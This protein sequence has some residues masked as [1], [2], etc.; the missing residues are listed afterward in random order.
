M[1]RFFLL[2]IISI[3]SSALFS[4]GVDWNRVIPPAE[5]VELTFEDRLVQLAWMNYSENRIFENEAD[6]T[7]QSIRLARWGWLDD[8][9]FRVNVN[10]RTIGDVGNF[11]IPDTGVDVNLF[12]WYNLGITVNPFTFIKTPAEK[13]LAEY[14]SLNAHRRLEVQKLSLRA[15]VLTRYELYKH[16]LEQ[17][18]VI[19]ENYE[20][21]NSTFI[22]IRER[23]NKGTAPLEDFNAASQARTEALTG[24]MSGELE[25]KLAKIRLEELI[26][27]PLEDV[28]R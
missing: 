14:E 13:Q 28:V 24:K 10:P 1:K 26:G 18:K 25:L 20:T 7:Y 4:Q 12:P 3:T 23:F 5:S 17:L 2:T 16:N 19:S 9:E 22:L 8:I 6:A 11:S 27:I 21:A 15:E